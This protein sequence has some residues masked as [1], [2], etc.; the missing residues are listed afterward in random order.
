MTMTVFKLTVLLA[1]CVSFNQCRIHQ[2]KLED[3]ER[4]IIQMSTFGFLKKGFLEV[5]I[6]F[7]R[8]KV[9]EGVAMNKKDM[10]YGFT[11]DKSGSSGISA[12]LENAQGKNCLLKN[13]AGILSKENNKNNSLSIIFFKID[14]DQM[15]VT[16]QR[17]GSDV[18]NLEIVYENLTEPHSPSKRHVP[19][20][21]FSDQVLIGKRHKREDSAAAS[22]VKEK[23]TKPPSTSAV[24]TTTTSKTAKVKTETSVTKKP[25]EPVKIKAARVLKKI[26]ISKFDNNSVEAYSIYFRVNINRKEEEGLYNLYFHNCPSYKAAYSVDM[27]L[28]ITE[29]NDATYLSAGEI[30]LAPLYFSFFVLYLAAGCLWMSVLKKSSDDVYKIHY[31]MFAVV[32]V[33]SFSSMF[34][35]VNIYYIGKEGIH[36]EA[37]AVLYYIVYLTKGSLM[38]IT[39]I[40]VGAGWAFVKHILSDKEKKLFLI[41]IPLQVFDN[42]A[43]IIIEESEEGQLQ[44]HIWKQLFIMID[45]LCCGAILFPVVWSIRHL[46]EAS[47]TDGKAA[48]CLLKLKLFRQ[49][50]I[51]VVC[52]IYFTRIIVYLIS[53]TVP[54][55]YEWLDQL[56]KELATI[57]FFIVTGYKFRPANDNPYLQVPQDSDEEVEMEEVVTQSGAYDNITRVNQKFEEGG[58]TPKQR[59][60]SHEYD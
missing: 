33:K 36:E 57:T 44:Y 48:I 60:S 29:K 38:I 46:T 37:W 47:N 39:I 55:Q 19:H 41:I 43:Y 16:I 20:S 11:L 17:N 21:P 35:A 8:Y 42:I 15:V 14:F 22:S 34:H 32:I 54:F 51:M 52:Y 53:I 49:F 1:F 3:D 23:V 12:Y 18:K 59:E 50:Y 31:L 9:P 28:K 10:L 13:P 4:K 25:S 7:F 58:T 5:S 24:P 26:P 56:F 40:L 27:T 6:S 2:L 30:P 45:L